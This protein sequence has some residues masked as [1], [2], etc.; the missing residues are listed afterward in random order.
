[1]TETINLNDNM[2]ANADALIDVLPWNPIYDGLVIEIGH[3]P[4]T[5][6]GDLFAGHI[7]AAISPL[8]LAA[9]LASIYGTQAVTA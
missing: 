2:V 3:D 8:D 7:I 9:R 4:T 5:R 6:Y 1:M